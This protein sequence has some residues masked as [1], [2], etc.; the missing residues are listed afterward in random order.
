MRDTTLAASPSHPGARYMKDTRLTA[1]Q[2]PKLRS[3]TCACESRV[4]GAHPTPRPTV[5]TAG[6]A[7]TYKQRMRTPALASVRARARGQCEARVKRTSCRQQFSVRVFWSRPAFS[8]VR[9][10]QRESTWRG[11]YI[12]SDFCKQPSR[13]PDADSTFWGTCLALSEVALYFTSRCEASVALVPPLP[14]DRYDVLFGGPNPRG[15]YR[16]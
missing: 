6:R 5:K 7:L 11:I 2:T 4:R 14:C 16:E 10:A 3:M 12:V 1:I 9:A 8:S 15:R 13:L